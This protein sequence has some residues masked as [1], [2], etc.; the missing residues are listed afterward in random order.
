MP[1]VT[2]SNYFA[3]SLLAAVQGAI[4]G[5]VLAL[6]IIVITAVL[7]VLAV[8]W[9][10]RYC[11]QIFFCIDKTSFFRTSKMSM[12]GTSAKSADFLMDQHSGML[13]QCQL[14]INSIFRVCHDFRGC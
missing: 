3:H 4:I 13:I 12:L 1:F 8:Y 9:F 14:A 7:V 2:G 5:G 10:K 11:M 6:M